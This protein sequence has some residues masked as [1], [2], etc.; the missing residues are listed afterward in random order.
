[1]AGPRLSSL[2]AHKPR[3]AA[4][5]A[6]ENVPGRRLVAGNQYNGKQAGRAA[7][8]SGKTL[9]SLII[10][11]PVSSLQEQGLEQRG[12]LTRAKSFP[13]SRR[14]LLS[15]TASSGGVPTKTVSHLRKSQL[16]LLVTRTSDFPAYNGGNHSTS[17]SLRIH[18]SGDGAL[19]R[20]REP[21][22]PRFPS[23]SL[24]RSV[25]RPPGDGRGV[26]W[27]GVASPLVALS[28]HEP[29]TH[30]GETVEIMCEVSR[31]FGAGS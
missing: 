9:V 18:Q 2:P 7:P 27:G 6:L 26:G 22:R 30:V 8:E 16:S 19:G 14:R 11:D 29:S 17:P 15:S 12:D 1:M 23:R 25:S 13:L 4:S 3:R 31:E 21:T 24:C 10:L 20:R 5:R 28:S